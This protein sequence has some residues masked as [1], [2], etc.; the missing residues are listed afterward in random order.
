MAAKN[1]SIGVVSIEPKQK[2][3]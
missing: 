3:F 1:S 2:K